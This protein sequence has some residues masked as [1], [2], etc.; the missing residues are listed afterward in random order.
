M[1]IMLKVEEMLCHPSA[2]EPFSQSEL[3]ASLSLSEIDAHKRLWVELFI[4]TETVREETCDLSML[5]RILL[6][7]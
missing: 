2:D 7:D 6:S 5:D 1:R 4:E 3:R